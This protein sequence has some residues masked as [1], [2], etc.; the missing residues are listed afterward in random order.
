[1]C[2][3]KYYLVIVIQISCRGPMISPRFL[4]SGTCTPSVASAPRARGQPLTQE[5]R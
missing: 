2:I 5:A 1:M 4:S 3:M